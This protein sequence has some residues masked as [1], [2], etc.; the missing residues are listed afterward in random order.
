MKLYS[1]TCISEFIRSV[2]IVKVLT[3]IDKVIQEERSIVLAGDSI[4]HFEQIKDVEMCSF[5]SIFTEVELFEY[6]TTKQCE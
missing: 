1:L 6:T 5:F 2:K 4:G 3:A